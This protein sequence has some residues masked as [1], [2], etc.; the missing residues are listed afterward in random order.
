MENSHSAALG[1]CNRILTLLP[2]PGQVKPSLVLIRFFILHKIIQ[3]FPVGI[4][5]LENMKAL[6]NKKQNITRG[7]SFLGLS[8]FVWGFLS[9]STILLH[10]YTAACNSSFSACYYYISLLSHRKPMESW[11]MRCMDF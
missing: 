7:M 1:T 2:L 10:F 9:T 4:I 8:L 11:R 6:V 3:H 5:Y